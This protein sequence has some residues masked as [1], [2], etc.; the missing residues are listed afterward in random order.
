[1]AAE[2][3]S[4]GSPPETP[5]PGP[6]EAGVGPDGPWGCFRSGGDAA[7]DRGESLVTLGPKV[8]MDGGHWRRDVAILRGARAQDGAAIPRRAGRFGQAW[9]DSDAV[10]LTRGGRARPAEFPQLRASASHVIGSA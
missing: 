10:V 1:M 5:P 2:G 8:R 7:A 3:A 6:P 9:L 4:A